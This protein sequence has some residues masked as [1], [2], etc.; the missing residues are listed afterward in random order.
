[1]RPRRWY[2]SLA[3]SLRVEVTVALMVA[4]GGWLGGGAAW[5][6]MPDY[7]DAHWVPADPN[8][9]NVGRNTAVNCVVIHDTEG[10][11][12]SAIATF[13]DPNRIASAN[14]VIR[15][16]DGDITQMVQDADT[17]FH[18]GNYPIN[19]RCIGIEHEGFYMD[20]AT[21]YTEVM[22]EASA[23]LVAHLVQKFNIPV[24]NTHIFGHYAVP[25]NENDPNP[26]TDTWQNCVDSGMYGG[27]SH[28]VDP[29]PGW[30]WD[31]Y[32]ALV[33]AGGTLT[34][35]YAAQW[36]A[37][38]DT[39]PMTSGDVAMVTIDY[40]NT[41]TVTWDTTSTRLGT[42]EPR[43][44]PSQFQVTSGDNA[45]LANNRPAAVS[46][47]TAPGASG[48]FAFA[49]QAPEVDNETTF[50]ENFNLVQ[51]GVQWFD[52]PAD[53]QVFLTITVRPRGAPAADGGV[54]PGPDGGV[55]ADAVVAPGPDGS[56]GEPDGP[57][58]FPRPPRDD[59]GNGSRLGGQYN[60]VGGGCSVA[61]GGSAGALPLVGAMVLLAGLAMRRRGGGRR[62]E[63][64]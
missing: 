24:D 5:A 9:Y 64:A 41:G 34:P 30:D 54:T 58:H 23:K 62:K 8:N 42:T 19:S 52:S 16:A 38:S 37:Q 29:G 11:Y 26:C 59:A 60:A 53:T 2:R 39:P 57:T 31:H 13:Q 50:T 17:A 6:D 3:R 44:R 49:I 61:S 14:Y 45:W 1:M 28:H 12:D 25:S 27:A 48:R 55:D 46:A 21:W 18:A 22:Y 47:E 40:T 36:T 10:S 4:A 63:G 43:D 33:R 56:A 35:A 32:F 7:P 51:E 15:S 20:P